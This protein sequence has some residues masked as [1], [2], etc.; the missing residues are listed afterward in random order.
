MIQTKSGTSNTELYCIY[1]NFVKDTFFVKALMIGNQEGIYGDASS[2]VS[3][4]LIVTDLND[5][6]FVIMSTQLAQSSAYLA[7]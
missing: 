4:R 2:G 7:L 1:N 6:K 5:E 3:Y